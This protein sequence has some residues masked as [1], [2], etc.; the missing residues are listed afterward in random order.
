MADKEGFLKHP[1][2]TPKRRPVQVRLTDWKEVYEDF[3]E[4]MLV[5]QASRCMNCGVAGS[6]IPKS[7]SFSD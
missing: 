4:K 3:D 7:I 6:V 1:R 5:D 2:V